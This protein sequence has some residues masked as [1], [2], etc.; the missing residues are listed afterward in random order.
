MES[1]LDSTLLTIL[2]ILTFATVLA[3]VRAQKRDRCLM[4]FRGYHVT[5]AEKDGKVRWGALEVRSSGLEIDYPEPT[6]TPKGFWKQSMLFYKEQYE[7]MDGVYRCTAG[8]SEQQKQARRRYLRR[9]SNPGIFLRMYRTLRNW[10][11]MIRDALVQAVSLLIGV[12]RSQ[13]QPAASVLARDEERFSTLSAELIG[14]AGNAYDPLLE[15]HL[16][17]RIIVAVTRQGS[18]HEYCGYLADYTSDFLEIIDAQVNAEEHHLEPQTFPVDQVPIDDV[19]IHVDA[20]FLR[21]ENQS[22]RMLLLGQLKHEG[23]AFKVG[24]VIPDGFSAALRLGTDIDRDTL[25]LVVS[26]PDGV[27]MLVPRSHAIIRHG[28]T[29]LERDELS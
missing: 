19:E 10:V 17:T 25:Q 2:V 27:D 5:L 15:K 16:F 21:V 3:I 29:A 12:A 11:G 22:G 4:H 1:F 9:T 28:V 23:E 13:A 6:R 20:N 7:A 24:A 26:T 18:T 8:L 14:H